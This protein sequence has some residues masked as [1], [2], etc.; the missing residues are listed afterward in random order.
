MKRFRLTTKNRTP[1]GFIIFPS[2]NQ[3]DWHTHQAL[4][5]AQGM[6]QLSITGS[7]PFRWPR[8][9]NSFENHNIVCKESIHRL[10]QELAGA[11]QRPTYPAW[12]VKE[13]SGGSEGRIEYKAR[14]IS[15]ELQGFGHGWSRGTK[16]RQ[17]VG[18][19]GW[20]MRGLLFMLRC[21]PLK[22]K[23]P[24]EPLKRKS[25]CKKVT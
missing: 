11:L 4:R 5:E 6:P 15:E 25:V 12:G 20:I 21:L 3:V 13:L 8:H 1:R 14:G 23:V 19:E 2:L 17:K 16:K 22:S 9:S 10:L 18:W 24:G 7:F